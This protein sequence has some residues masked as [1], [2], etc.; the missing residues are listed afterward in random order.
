M[1]SPVRSFFELREALVTLAAVEQVAPHGGTRGLRRLGAHRIQ[2][3]AVLLLDLRQIGAPL[4]RTIDGDA[5]RLPWNDETAEI[6]E[7]AHELR[8]F[9]RL[10][11]AAVEGE[12]LVDTGVAAADRPVDRLIGV[13]D[14]GEPGR[15][16]ALRGEA[17][18]LDLDAGAQL[19]DLDHL[20]QRTQL[21][22]LDAERPARRRR[23]ESAY[24]L[25]GDDK[26]LGAQRRDRL[27]HDGAADAGGGDHFLLGRQPRAGREISGRN[28]GGEALAESM[29]PAALRRQ[30]TE[31]REGIAT[32][33]VRSCHGGWSGHN[34]T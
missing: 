30:W 5:D 21:A 13:A 24:A 23:D 2:D 28:V 15:R 17:G 20:A 8:I 12:I 11:N 18:G 22:A 14:P 27:A 29:G 34:M 3:V 19:H 32:I 6:F 25:A 9:G 1:G 4:R 31:C 16:G 7:K 33:G 26:S 10:R